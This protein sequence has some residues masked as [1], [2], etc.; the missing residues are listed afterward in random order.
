MNGEESWKKRVSDKEHVRKL[1]GASKL[2]DRLSMIEDNSKNWQK[3][4]G[5]EN[6]AKQFTVE[7]KI[8]SK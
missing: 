3:N 2:K 5:Q 1:P 4:V 7:G 6:D 8:A